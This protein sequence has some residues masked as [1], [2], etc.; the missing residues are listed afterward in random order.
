MQLNFVDFNEM[1][2]KQVSKMHD[3]KKDLL[4]TMAA[5]TLENWKL[6]G[7]DFAGLRNFSQQ[8]MKAKNVPKEKFPHQ[9]CLL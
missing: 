3:S 2:N 8:S 5:A 9:E 6:D 7:V 1:N 4:Q